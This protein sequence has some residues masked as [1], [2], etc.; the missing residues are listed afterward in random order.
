MHVMALFYDFSK[1]FDCVDHKIL[2]KK[3]DHY[4]IRGTMLNWFK[5]YLSNRR[6]FVHINNTNSEMC[7]ASFGVPQGS[8][9]GP[10]LY[11][12]YAN[13]LSNVINTD[14]S[15][16]KLFADDSNVF[17]YHSHFRSL[18]TLANSICNVMYKWCL[19][20]NLSIN[21]S[22]C[23]YMVFKPSINN[24]TEMSTGNYNIWLNGQKLKYVESAKFLGL[25]IDNKLTWSQHID[26]LVKRVNMYTSWFYKI[27]MMLTEDAGRKLYYA[28]VHSSIL[29]GLLLYGNANKTTMTRLQVSHNRSLRILQK[30]PYRTHNK[31]LYNNYSIMSI[32]DLFVL[33]NCKLIFNCINN[34]NASSLPS[35]IIVMFNNTTH[36]QHSTRGS[37]SNLLYRDGI[38]SNSQCKNIYVNNAISLWNGLPANL[39]M[40]KSYRQFVLSCKPLIITDT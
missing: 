33:E 2:L 16:I 27:R 4:G 1:A 38:K 30:L 13:D 18:F 21:A 15:I 29:Y 36:H 31:T 6:H 14:N 22:K 11:I 37:N 32:S 17:L 24:V 8:I 12:I 3:L 7:V 10:L 20:N 40:C 9:L 19:A 5:S 34:I 26:N 39:R 23:S 35:C 28:Y 25:T